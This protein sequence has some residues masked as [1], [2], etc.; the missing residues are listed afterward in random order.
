MRVGIVAVAVVA[1][2]LGGC[3]SLTRGTSEQVQIVSDP[4][5]AEVRTT[6]GLVCIT[7]CSLPVGRKD[8]FVATF[9]KPGYE[10]VSVPVVT[11]IGGTGAAGFAGNVV[12]G[13]LIGMG[14]DAATGAALDH[15]PNPVAV[16]MRPIRLAAVT[17]PSARGRRSDVVDPVIPDRGPQADPSAHCK[18]VV[19]PNT[20][21]NDVR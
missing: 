21:R 15:C 18:V 11:R 13:G 14:V 10:A 19:D 12:L 1:A 8:E 7:P 6:S 20:A 4:P 16:T 17:F 2:G 9:T 3:A 5:G